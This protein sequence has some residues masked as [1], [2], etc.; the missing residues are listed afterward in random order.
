M[1]KLMF[2]VVKGYRL[3]LFLMIKLF[4]V[5]EVWVK[6]DEVKVMFVLFLGRWKLGIR[7]EWG[8]VSLGCG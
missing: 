2:F 5:C 1:I 8:V 7:V 3:L 6:G 4:G